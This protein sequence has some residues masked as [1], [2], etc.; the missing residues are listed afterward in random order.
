MRLAKIIQSSNTAFIAQA[1]P[2]IL[3]IES[4]SETLESNRWGPS[5]DK[6]ESK[7]WTMLRALPEASYVGLTI[8]RF[9]GRMPYGSK[10]EPTETFS[11]EELLMPNEDDNYLWVNSSFACALL[12]AQ[13][14]SLHE[15]EIGQNLLHDIENLSMYMYKDAG[16]T[17]VKSP[18][19]VELNISAA[20]KIIEQGL[21]PFVSFRNSDNIRLARF[22]SIAS[23]PSVLRGK[24]IS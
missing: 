11:F 13:S 1:S 3:G 8:P 23:P 2:E 9:M 5:E 14:F 6:P 4:L 7:L 21:M 16:Q 15:W 19:E 20:E 22:Q 10:S 17:I 12:L 24:W 18:V